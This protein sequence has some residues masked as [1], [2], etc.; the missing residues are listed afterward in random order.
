MRT[1]RTMLKNRPEF[2]IHCGDHIYADCPIEAELKLP[3]GEV[4]PGE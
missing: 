1:Y 2:F 4:C 3:N